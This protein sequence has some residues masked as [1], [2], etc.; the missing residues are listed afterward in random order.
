MHILCRLWTKEKDEPS[1][2]TSYQYVFELRERLE[3]MLK[4]AREKLEKSQTQQKQYFNHKCKRRELEEGDQV[5]LLQ[6][7]DRNKLIM[8]WKGPYVIERRVGPVDYAVNV[9]G[10]SKVFHVNLLKQYYSRINEVD[11]KRDTPKE[12]GAVQKLVS[13]A[14]ISADGEGGTDDAVDDDKLLDVSLCWE[15]KT[16]DD[17][18]LGEE[19]S[20]KQRA[21][22]Q[23]LIEEF[24]PVF[25]RCAWQDRLDKAASR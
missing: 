4:L 7:T 18:K 23:R 17:V 13:S 2:Q 6:P 5:L 21:Q 1:V 12:G 25:Y 20:V 10:K 15:R 3:E 8:K 24:S 22:A 19:L 14:I 11:Q 16:L 9:K